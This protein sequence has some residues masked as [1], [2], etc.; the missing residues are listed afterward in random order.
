MRALALL[1]L[2]CA[3]TLGMICVV[4]GRT[5]DA[6]ASSALELL[7]DLDQEAPGELRVEVH[8][9][10]SGHSYRLGFRS[11]VRNIGRGALIIEG[12]RADLFTPEM[13]AN[14]LVERTDGAPRVVRRVG[15]LAYVE[16]STH[17]HWHLLD[18]DRYELRQKGSSRGLVRD[19]KSGFCLGDRYRVRELRLRATPQHKVFRTRCG[20]TRRD[21][22]RV[23]EGISV[24]YADHYRPFLEGQ[25]LPLDGLPD[26]RYLLVHQVNADR[27]LRELSFGNNA[28]STLI[29]L[30]W[31]GGR[32]K[33]R[34]LASCADSDVCNR[35]EASRP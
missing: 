5:V 32:P 35:S 21:L 25:S 33:V 13:R 8:P 29:E 28:A 10:G 26:G 4:A 20:L 27:R 18:F 1:A 12:E 23:R 22:F 17:Q 19:R 31:R 2:A 34:I 7:P 14:Q 3:V 9:S 16:A 24:G 30:R 15:R 11:A 6:D